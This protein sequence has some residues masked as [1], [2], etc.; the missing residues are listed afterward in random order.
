[1]LRVTALI[2]GLFAG[3]C[4]LFAWMS[5]TNN[6]K[7]A[8]DLGKLMYETVFFAGMICLVFPPIPL[9]LLALLLLCILLSGD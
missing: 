5:S 7:V 6:G 2:Y 8:A 9:I 3:L 1:M 4:L